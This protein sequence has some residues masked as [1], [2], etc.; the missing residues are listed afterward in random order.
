MPAKGIDERRWG[1]WLGSGERE[2]AVVAAI[3]VRVSP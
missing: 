2:E 3:F 1:W